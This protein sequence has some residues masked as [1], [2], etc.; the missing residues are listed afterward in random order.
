MRNQMVQNQF[1]MH[2]FQ[3]FRKNAFCPKQNDMVAFN[4]LNEH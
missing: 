2:L 1:L 4:K 3:R